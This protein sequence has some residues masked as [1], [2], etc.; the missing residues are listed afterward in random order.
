MVRKS[1]KQYIIEDDF[2]GAFE[3]FETITKQWK[4]I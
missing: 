2:E 1:S 3:R 4:N